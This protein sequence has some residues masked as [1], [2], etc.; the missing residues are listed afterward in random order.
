MAS[1]TPLCEVL[2]NGV[3]L[4]PGGMGG[5]LSGGTLLG[6]GVTQHGVIPSALAW[7]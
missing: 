1:Q 7:G 4:N 3:A 6:C 2:P 5:G